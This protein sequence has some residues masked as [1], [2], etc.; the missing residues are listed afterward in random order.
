[1]DLLLLLFCVISGSLHWTLTEE[2]VNTD[3]RYSEFF[4]WLYVPISRRV[5]APTGQCSVKCVAAALTWLWLL[6]PPPNGELARRLSS[7]TS[8]QPPHPVSHPHTPGKSFEFGS[9][10]FLLHYVFSCSLFQGK[11]TGAL[12]HT[13]H[14]N[15]E[16]RDF[17]QGRKKISSNIS[18]KSYGRLLRSPSGWSHAML[19]VPT[20]EVEF[21]WRV[22]W[23]GGWSGRVQWYDSP[24][25][26]LSPVFTALL[27]RNWVEIL[28]KK[29]PLDVHMF[30]VQLKTFYMIFN[31]KRSWRI[32]GL[33]C[34]FKTVYL[35]W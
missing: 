16:S 33:S 12:I 32:C 15:F 29:W 3:C 5:S 23:G 21:F 14:Y 25:C 18:I 1:M 28:P 31:L 27:W 10:P 13:A 20:R 6:V 26:L 19:P 22:G 17:K 9:F 7:V 35:Q 4:F 8:F 2:N 34:N 24:V 30:K 11:S